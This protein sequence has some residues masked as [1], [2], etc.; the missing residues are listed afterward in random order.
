MNESDL[1]GTGATPSFLLFT[2]AQRRHDGY[3]SLSLLLLLLLARVLYICS[4]T[5]AV[6]PG[7]LEE[8]R[9]TWLPVIAF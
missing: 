7:T 6:R 4:S 9:S 3:L 8:E 5:R 2:S 1:S